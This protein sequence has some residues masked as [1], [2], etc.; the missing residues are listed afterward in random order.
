MLNRNGHMAGIGSATY[1]AALIVAGF[2]RCAPTAAQPSAPPVAHPDVGHIS[3]PDELLDGVEPHWAIT[4]I[5][6][7][8]VVEIHVLTRRR[9]WSPDASGR[10]QPNPVIRCEC[11]NRTQKMAAGSAQ[12]PKA[13]RRLMPGSGWSPS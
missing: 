4:G 8:K 2:L 11:T 5:P 3:A 7:G 10:L 6:S 13:K 9:R 12:K 1:G